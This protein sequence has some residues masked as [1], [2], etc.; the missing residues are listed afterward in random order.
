VL[1]AQNPGT[2]HCVGFDV[3]GKILLSLELPGRNQF[4]GVLRNLGEVLPMPLLQTLN[5]QSAPDG[6]TIL[7]LAEFF[8]RHSSLDHIE[9]TQCPASL[10]RLLIL[11]PNRYLCPQLTKLSI[12]ECHIAESDLLDIVESRT[13]PNNETPTGHL[14]QIVISRCV[15]ITSKFISKLE[16]YLTVDYTR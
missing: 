7:L 5:L 6:D 11:E 12:S 3:A 8:A 4:P 13:V 9:F 1:T 14:Q 10:L 16:V 15:T 2:L